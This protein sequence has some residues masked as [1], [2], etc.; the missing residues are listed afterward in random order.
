MLKNLAYTE[1]HDLHKPYDAIVRT[2]FMLRNPL[3]VILARGYAPH[4][5]SLYFDD[6]R[7][8][9]R[10]TYTEEDRDRDESLDDIL[11][12]DPGNDP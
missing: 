4:I 7:G 8:P 10:I 3:E 6:E 2:L 12:D 5:H 1:S 9:L 11:G